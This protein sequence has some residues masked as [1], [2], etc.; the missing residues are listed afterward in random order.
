VIAAFDRKDKEVL[1]EAKIVQVV[2]DDTHKMGVDWEAVFEH[3]DMLTLKSDF[4]ILNPSD[5]SGRLSIGASGDDDYGLVIEALDSSGK[6]NILSNPR[7]TVVNEKEAKIL[8]G[9]T[10]PYV[11]SSVTTTAAGPVTTSESVNF[12]DVGV[13]LYVTP[14]IHSDG[15]IT[16]K[17]KPEVSSVTGEVATS[18]NNTIPVIET[19]EVETTVMV[20]DGVMIIIGGLIKEETSDQMKKVP[21]LGSIPILGGVFRSQSRNKRKTEI[22]VFI[23]PHIINGD[24]S[25]L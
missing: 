15:F 11:T 14:K 5:K 18:S 21:V 23:T 6:V 3:A 8:V 2:L 4:D 17:I 19:S 7:I 9:S 12:I 22:V 24:R 13:K 20:K 25:I 10:E 1:I 16:I